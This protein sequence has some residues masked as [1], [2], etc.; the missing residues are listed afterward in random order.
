[1]SLTVFQQSK[2]QR[3]NLQPYETKKQQ[4]LTLKLEA[5]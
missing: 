4:I 2:I 3:F 1:M 5:E